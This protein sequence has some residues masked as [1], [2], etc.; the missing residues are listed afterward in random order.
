MQTKSD[1]EYNLEALLRKWQ[2][3]PQLRE[4]IE[5]WVR[6][7]YTLAEATEFSR[8]LARF[9]PTPANGILDEAPREVR[10]PATVASPR[11]IAEAKR[12]GV[13]AGVV[14]S[15]HAPVPKPE[16]APEPEPQPAE[17][18][19]VE[20]KVNASSAEAPAEKP[21][22]DDP[23]PGMPEAPQ[24]GIDATPASSAEPEPEVEAEPIGGRRLNT[25]APFEMAG[26]FLVDRFSRAGQSL[27]KRW[28]GDFYQWNGRHYEE[29]EDEDLEAEIYKYL[30]GIN[31]GNFDPKE[32]DVN[33]MV[34]ALKSVKGVRIGT[35]V[36]TGTWGGKGVPPWGEEAVI[37]CRNGILRL[38]DG[39]L[40][41][42]DPRLFNLGV[43]ETEY[44][45]EA[46]CPRWMQ[47]LSETWGDDY[48]TRGALQEFFGLLLSDISVVEFQKAFIIF[49]PPRSG[50]TLIS[51]IASMLLG[52]RNCCSPSLDKLSKQFGTQGMIGKKLAAVPDARLDNRSNRSAITEKLLST[53]SGD[54][55]DIERKYKDDWHGILQI[56]MMILTNV[57]PDFK[58]ESGAIATRFVILQ[59][60]NSYLGKED[61]KLGEKLQTELSGILNWALEGLPRL[62][63][64]GRFL[65]PGD[66]ALK[67]EL[68]SKASV[69]HSFVSD[70]CEFEAGA[71]VKIA[72]IHS[73]YQQ[74]GQKNNHRC[75]LT[76]NL[77]AGALRGAF[78]GE[79]LTTR[80]R[81]DSD[82]SRPRW[83]IGVRLR[84]GR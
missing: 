44:R 39:K 60:N 48:V 38:S 74:W 19:A 80:P 53:I 25:E 35:R 41:P 22:P 75:L 51:S 43:V 17:K 18:P 2:T 14:S 62:V 77:L 55:Q 6:T 7:E 49:G 66:G 69:I 59:T 12:K 50:K 83:F 29:L 1:I 81:D 56:R 67:R 26:F 57:L 70:C 16:A 8:K 61:N 47:F 79:F 5:E 58:D 36:E 71:E 15:P 42:H 45:P 10:R 84:K 21:R 52:A 46:E 28:R 23:P 65:E 11:E 63:D 40:F 37:C 9:A 13:E 68:A 33:A 34:H 78:P 54:S 3:E 24:E 31:G 20:Q 32:R 64:R 4:D 72:A 27:L 30:N 82:P 76:A 73:A